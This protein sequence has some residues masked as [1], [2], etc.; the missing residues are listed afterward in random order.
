MAY[1]LSKKNI[2]TA[3]FIFFVTTFFVASFSRAQEEFPEGSF[4]RAGG[5]ERM[6]IIS[7]GRKRHITTEAV[8]NSYGKGVADV[9]EADPDIL[10]GIPDVRVMRLAGSTDIYDIVSGQ[11]ELIPSADEFLG[12]GYVW[13]E[14]SNVNRTELDSYA[15]VVVPE[16][17]LFPSPTPGVSPT[18]V[19]PTPIP[20]PTESLLLK[21]IAQARDLLR[22]AAP[23]YPQEHRLGAGGFRKTAEQVIALQKKLQQLGFFPASVLPN[24]NYGPAT[25]QAVKAFQQSKGLSQ[26][27][28]V[29]PQTLA[30]LQKVGLS[31]PSTG[32][33][34]KNWRAAAPVTRDVL[35]AAW[36]ETTGDIRLIHATIGSTKI[37]VGK[38]KVTVPIAH[39]ETAGF[40][41]HYQSGNGANTRYLVT[42]PPGYQVLA[43]RYPIFDSNT[44]TTTYP[45]DE[46]VY[47]PYNDAFR[48]PE[49][50]ASGRQYLDRVITQALGDLGARQ[51]QS[52]TGRGLIADLT[53]PDELKNIAI[54]EH[55]DPAEFGRTPDKEGVVNKVFTIL[56]TNREDAFKFSGSSKGALG[57]AQFIRSTYNIIYKQYPAAALLPG[58]EA[59]MAN[60]VNAIKAMALYHDVSGATL[61][62]LVRE[63]IAQEPADLAWVLAEIRAAA[64]NGGA[65]RVKKVVTVLGPQWVSTTAEAK[66][67][68]NSEVASLKAQIK[69]ATGSVKTALNA[70]L[71]QKQKQVASIASTVLRNETITYLQKFRVVRQILR[72]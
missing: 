67:T 12:R 7:N 2:T 50:V 30:A 24:G 46:E 55:I 58:F 45:P 28:T 71:K 32:T 8:L 17:I 9:K 65:G 53:D 15:T 59:G 34:V 35:L 56:G 26:P 47:V 51:I 11:K 19:S 61:E 31:F 3:V 36:N 63:R 37:K 60:H 27:G 68:L 66:K 4:W 21:K 54:I 49:I 10:F 41:V 1:M 14:V 20:S 52:A 62:N 5:D 64:Y 16:I 40:S 22:A 43:N 6:Y 70:Q 33:L 44:G 48:T 25:T 23:L 29:G 69:A 39:S 18:S 72:Q 38:K 42:S 13:D 57:L